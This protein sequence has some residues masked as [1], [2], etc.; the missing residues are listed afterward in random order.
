MTIK[1]AGS[2]WSSFLS[3]ALILVQIPF[4]KTQ[5]RASLWYTP[6]YSVLPECAQGCLGGLSG[7][8]V[9]RALDCGV[10][11]YNVCFCNTQALPTATSFISSCVTNACTKIAPNVPSAIEVY[12]DYCNNVN[13]VAAAT[14]DNS[15]TTA[16]DKSAATATGNSILSTPATTSGPATPASSSGS[17]N[18]AW[19]S[20]GAVAGY[21]I[22]GVVLTAIGA[23]FGYRQWK[24]AKEADKRARHP[25]SQAGYY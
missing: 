23:F 21:T 13:K 3:L 11:V 12:T 18:P 2:R 5:A 14:T 22:A 10:I 7:D 24:L 25:F 8:T 4:A 15:A 20:P 1:L 16:T 9:D 6:Q 19:S 17:N